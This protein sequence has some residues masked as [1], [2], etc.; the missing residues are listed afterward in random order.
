M[1]RSMPLSF[2]LSATLVLFL[3]ATTPVRAD[4]LRC[5]GSLISTGAIAG[6]VLE[7]CGPPDSKEEVSE[8]VM[9]RRPNG[10]TYQVGTTTKEIWRY[11]RGPREFPAVL[12]FEGGVLKKLVFEK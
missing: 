2:L 7:K 10:S 5:G 9:A 4:T 8:P 11:K 3:V 12:T 6:N 1:I